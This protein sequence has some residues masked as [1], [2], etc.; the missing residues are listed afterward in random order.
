MKYFLFP[1]CAFFTL[2]TF[3]QDKKKDTK[4]PVYNYS[5]NDPMETFNPLMG[6][7]KTYRYYPEFYSYSSYKIAD[8]TFQ[9]ECYDS[10]DSVINP[11]AIKDIGDVRFISL[12]KGYLDP[13]QTYKD[14][15]GTRKPLPVSSIIRRYDR[16]GNDKWMSIAYATNKYTELKESRT[17]IVRTDTMLVTDPISNKETATINCYYKVAPVK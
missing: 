3:A 12:F 1:I 2:S 4:V 6:V 16:V 15:D 10:R 14:Y 9:F 11:L 7:E 13:V 8:T 17:Y 5:L